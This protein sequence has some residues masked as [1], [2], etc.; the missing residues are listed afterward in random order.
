MRIS[1]KEYYLDTK[2]LRKVGKSMKSKKSIN[3]LRE[4]FDLLT[5]VS[6]LALSEQIKQMRRITKKT[7]INYAKWLGIAPRIIIDLENG[8]GNPTLST[9]IKIGRPFGLDIHFSKNKKD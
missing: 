9:L 5:P 3:E 6:K 1:E 4:E 8:K 2:A 7:Q